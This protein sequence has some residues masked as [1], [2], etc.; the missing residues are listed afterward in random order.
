MQKFS[1][2]YGPKTN[3][4]E[5]VLYGYKNAMKLRK[6]LEADKAQ[7]VRVEALDDGGDLVVE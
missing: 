7:S 2:S 4:T 6:E 3:R 5:V 1:I